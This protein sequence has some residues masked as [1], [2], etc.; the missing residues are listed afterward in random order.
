M[1]MGHVSKQMPHEVKKKTKYKVIHGE[2]LGAVTRGT[3]EMVLAE[4]PNKSR[5]GPAS[6]ADVLPL[7]RKFIKAG[8]LGLFHVIYKQGVR[9]PCVRF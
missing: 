9:V 5:L 4:I 6:S 7:V 3:R 8:M 1:C 2:W